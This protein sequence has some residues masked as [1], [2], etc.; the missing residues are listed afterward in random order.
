MKQNN[1]TNKTFNNKADKAPATLQS[2][3]I[4]AI[5][6]KSTPD[7]KKTEDLLHPATSKNG[8]IRT[9]IA[10]QE[11]NNVENL[12]DNLLID[13][14]APDLPVAE[15]SFS[16]PAHNSLTGLDFLLPVLPQQNQFDSFEREPPGEIL[17]LNTRASENE[18]SASG[19]ALS[20]SNSHLDL[21]DFGLPVVTT[22]VET[23]IAQPKACPIDDESTKSALVGF[24]DIQV[25]DSE[26]ADFM[27]ESNQT[28]NSHTN[29]AGFPSAS[30]GQS[31]ALVSNVDDIYSSSYVEESHATGLAEDIANHDQQIANNEV[32]DTSVN[33]PKLEKNF[34]KDAVPMQNTVSNSAASSIQNVPSLSSTPDANDQTVGNS[35]VVQS[36]ESLPQA[37]VTPSISATIERQMHEQ[38][39]A[40]LSQVVV[41]NNGSV[42][43]TAPS[44]GA[45][46]VSQTS[47]QSLSV[48]DPVPEIQRI[49]SVSPPSYSSVIAGEYNAGTIIEETPAAQGEF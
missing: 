33:K 9:D 4:N 8:D 46:A 26:F 43:A 14:S 47:S 44:S 16:E 40:L 30:L 36:R 45:D 27:E 39:S 23:V 37:G 48:R 1:K 32:D 31:D 6:T 34:R 13:F 28:E 15:V 35:E 41:Q 3:S 29:P 5:T 25:D 38:D 24:N 11:Q 42:N 10:S 21:P 7:A 2:T 22:S 49:P 18:A 17:S 12:S 20:L 19:D